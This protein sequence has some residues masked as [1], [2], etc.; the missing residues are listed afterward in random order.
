MKLDKSKKACKNCSVNIKQAKEK[1]EALKKKDDLTKEE[2]QKIAEEEAALAFME[3][4]RKVEQE[5]EEAEE[6]GEEP[7]EDNG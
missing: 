2:R 4:D 3:N 1:L 6:K 7:A 5:T